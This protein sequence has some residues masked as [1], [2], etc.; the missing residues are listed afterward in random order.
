VGKVLIRAL[1][2]N[3]GFLEASPIEFGP[4]LNCIIGARGTCKSTIVETIRF[5][6]D[7]EVERAGIASEGGI[8]DATLRAGTAA[9]QVETII[10]GETATLV[11][12]REQG[13]DPRVYLDGVKQYDASTV[14]RCGEIFSQTDLQRIAEEENQEYRLAL[15]ER[16]SR[17]RIEELK[18]GRQRTLNDLR[19]IGSELRTIRSEVEQRRDEI[20]D[21]GA[22]RMQLQQTQAT[23]PELSAELSA[24]H[25]VFL[26]RQQIL[27]RV[28]AAKDIQTQLVA[29]LQPVI[30]LAAKLD[31]ARKGLPSD[32][33]TASAAAALN[34]VSDAVERI[35]ASEE[36]IRTADVEE[37]RRTLALKYDELNHE[38][39][40]LRQEQQDLN[41]ALKR[42]ETFRKQIEHL[43][44][45][46]RRLHE[47]QTTEARLLELRRD[48]RQS[49]ITS[50]DEIYLLRATEV[51]TVNREHGDTILLTLRQ[52]ALSAEYI[53]FLARLL[54]GSRLKTQ[55]DLAKDIAIK[56]A[57]AELL[58]YI[59]A[60]DARSLGE[61]LGRDIAQ[62][63]RIMAHL[64][65]HPE[66]YQLELQFF[67]DA[68]EITFYDNGT[69][70]PVESLSK[71]QR[72]TALLPLILRASDQPLIFDQP[73]DDL[74]NSFIY[75][76][77][78]E[79]VKKLRLDRQLIFVTHNANIPVLGEADRIIVMRMMS[80]TAAAPPMVGTVDQCKESI[81]TLLEGGKEAFERRQ[82]RYADL[83][84]PTTV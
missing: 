59:E 57:P 62:V 24:Q 42:E 7:N 64:R 22:L 38:Y 76:S 5:A 40:R 68:L 80:P 16:P 44:Q 6:L 21:L 69:P 13:S 23:R 39:F 41:E 26:E 75:R 56:V 83:L 20:R 48:A 63:T 1:K 53:S 49:G 34:G 73:E 45:S 52:G 27:Q 61:I 9:C 35:V 10:N 54:S 2:T 51:D 28:E 58:D 46:E 55:D 8:I 3:S 81:L 33:I 79:V 74:D 65:D 78:V 82:H 18:K 60:G 17:A 47:L 36:S 14:A 77:L 84:H 32:G 25:A 12:E 50:S 70:K 11:F 31:A 4:G 15:V 66:L 43:E 67:E 72:A 19:R 29:T 71:G 37:I 30:G